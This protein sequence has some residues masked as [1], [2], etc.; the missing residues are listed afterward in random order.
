MTDDLDLGY[1]ARALELAL[2][3]AASTD[4]NPA[5][6]CVIVNDGRVV[7]EGFT[8]PAGGNHAEIEALNAAG[9]AARGATCYVSLEPCAHTGR[10]GPCT[11]ALIEAQVAR[12]VFALEDPNPAVAGKGEAAL[13]AAGIRVESPLLA[14]EAETLNRGFVSRMRRGRPWIRCKMAASLDGRTALASGESQWITGEAARRDVH[15]WRARSSAVMTGIGTV[16]ADDP[17]LTAR[18]DEPGIEFLQPARIIVDATFRTPPAARTLAAGG[19]VIVF[20][21]AAPDAAVAARREA[22]ERAGARV[23][24]VDADGGT[25]GAGAGAGAG[26][27]DARPGATRARAGERVGRLD[28]AAIAARLGALEI[29]TVWLEA[30][31][32]LSGAMLA[33]GLVDELILYLAPCLLGDGARGLFALPPLERLADRFVLGIDDVAR[34]GDD[35]RIIARPAPREGSG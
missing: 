18:P 17:L 26:E 5:V 25:R 1:M 12:V 34:L 24:T 30:G 2:R 32:G 23:E 11:A 10:T 8:R 21:G 4:P 15:R 9:E 3:G 28:L 35:L 16:L 31:P 33:A 20:G 14:A 7:G 6:G 19:E 29:N 27:A 13:A 22:L